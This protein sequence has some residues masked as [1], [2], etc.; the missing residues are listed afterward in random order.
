MFF[1]LLLATLLGL[2]LG[3]LTGIIPGIHVNL[4]SAF[5]LSLSPLLLP[6]FSPL[7][8]CAFILS[9]AI[10]HSFLDVIP[11]TFLGIPEG[12]S[13]YIL[14]PSQQ[15]VLEGKAY[16]AIFLS[17][18]GAFGSFL[19]ALVCI[20][21]FL[22]LT[23]N[24]YPI[25]EPYIG[26]ILL[27]LCLFLL[28][29]EKERLW[30]TFIFLLSGT[31]GLV[32][33]SLPLEQGLFP[34]FSGLFGVSSLLLSLKESSTIPPQKQDVPELDEAPLAIPCATFM[35][36]IASFMP[37]L[38]PAQVATIS[39]RLLSLSDKGYLILL[40]G[41]STVNTLLA[42]LSF[43]LFEK[44][45]SGVLVNI[46]ELMRLDEYTL[47]LF[48]IIAIIAAGLA[49]VLTITSSKYF[50]LWMIRIN[51]FWLNITVLTFIVIMTLFLTGFLGFLI[52]I[53]STAIGIL[54]EMKGVAKSHMMGCL[55]LPVL[56]FFL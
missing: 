47:F 51:Y 53:V 27:L 15:L 38:G 14:F 32:V 6:Y 8:L 10:T 12:D 40:G 35:G 48:L 49:T 23:K 29:Q 52:L 44:T 13:P 18:F 7:L 42:L 50:S 54:P 39:T 19:L 31:L 30:A 16:Q 5:I 20:P 33:L 24:L 21:L 56:L 2:L 4:L 1:E 11:T 9:I 41:L 25:I 3:S 17:T 45:R 28:F 43:Y 34:L 55:L 26:W 37:G 46:A 22:F 36:W